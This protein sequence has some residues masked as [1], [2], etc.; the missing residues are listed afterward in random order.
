MQLYQQSDTM[1]NI[2]QNR[3]NNTNIN[4]SVKTY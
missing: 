4:K 3:R 2:R 1:Q